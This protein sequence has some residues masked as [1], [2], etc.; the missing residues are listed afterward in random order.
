MKFFNISAY[1]LPVVLLMLVSC[2]KETTESYEKVES[3]ALEAWIAQHRPDLIDNKQVEG[4]YYVDVLDAGNPDVSAVGQEDCWVKFGFTG[5]DLS[6]NIVMTRNAADAVLEGT[7]TKYTRYVPLYRYC[8]E[9]NTSL[10]EG[11]YLAM[12]NTLTVGEQYFNRY[13]SDADRRLT[14]REVRVR[15]GSKVVLYMP[16]SVV[17]GG[18]EGSGGYEGQYSLD[19]NRPMIV[20]L[21]IRDT[22]KNPLEAEGTAVDD[23]CDEN[24]ERRVYSKP[25]EGDMVD[26]DKPTIP[27]DPEDANHP[28]NVREAWTSA[29]D[30]V[31]QL[32]VN[33]RYTP[34]ET[35]NFPDPYVAGYQ[36][37]KDQGSVAS[38]NAQID[39]ALR[40]RFFSDGTAPY[41]DIKSFQADSV[42]LEG[43]AKIWYIGR[44][45]DGFIFDTNIDEVKEIIYGEVNSS[46]EALSYT[47][48][49][50]GM[51]TA[52]YYTIPHLKFGQWATII[53]TSTNAYGVSG[54]SGAS[55]TSSTGSSSSSYLDYLN[56]MNY[57]NSYYG[58]SGYYNNYYNSYYGYGGYYDGYYSSYYGSDYYGQTDESTTTT[59]TVTTEIPPYTPLI[60]QLY[61]EPETGE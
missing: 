45:L 44:F 34:D 18:V 12:R 15:G 25:E 14:S 31:A 57:M 58:S 56:Y 37:Y 26:N 52:F 35:L 8:G 13:K 22:V 20:T 48:S 47:P 51:I 33:Y 39:A 55:T 49:D 36:P 9:T 19:D 21:E 50:G 10:L 4:G 30:S 53:T 54:K 6:G 7:F 46:G 3:L 41:E 42:G 24:G 61:I 16:S 40:E 23:W 2:A 27:E 5:R 28:Y 38:I 17:G 1:L 11:T 60:F 43:T 32:Y 59:T 29:C